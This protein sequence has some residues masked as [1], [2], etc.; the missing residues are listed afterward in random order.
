MKES[1]VGHASDVRGKRFVEGKLGSKYKCLYLSTKFS[2]LVLVLEIFK[3]NV[4][5]LGP[6]VLEKIKYF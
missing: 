4:L 2:V 5:V 6:N 1:F 3:V